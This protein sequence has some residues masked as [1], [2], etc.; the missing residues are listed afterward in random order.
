MGMR[1]RLHEVSPVETER[2]PKNKVLREIGD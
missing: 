1:E 2:E